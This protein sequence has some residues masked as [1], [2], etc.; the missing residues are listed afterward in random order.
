[1]VQ[2]LEEGGYPAREMVPQ[3][4]HS[5]DIKAPSVRTLQVEGMTCKKCVGRVEK[6]LL[7]VAGVT[8][9]RVNLDAGTAEVEGTGELQ[10]MVQVLEEGGYPAREAGAS[11]GGVRTLQ[12]EGM[13]CNKCVGRVKKALLTVA[14]VTAAR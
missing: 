2:V 10:A 1:M 3:S 12:V 11:G 14:G 8:A 9:A 5:V 13:T 7:T 6:A 4:A